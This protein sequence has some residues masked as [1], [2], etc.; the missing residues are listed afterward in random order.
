MAKTVDLLRHFNVPE[1]Y[2]LAD[3]LMNESRN[4]AEQAESYAAQD[5]YD[6]WRTYQKDSV[7]MRDLAL[8]VQSGGNGVI[9]PS[10]MDIFD[11]LTAEIQRNP[12]EAGNAYALR[13]KID[14]IVR[15]M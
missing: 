2:D 7:Y 3:L 14:E 10:L 15:T 9:K 11:V 6:M 1:L 13:A 8:I 4:S 12:A 5:A